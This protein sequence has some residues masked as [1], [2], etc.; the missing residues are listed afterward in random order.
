MNRTEGW[1][2]PLMRGR[3]DSTLDVPLAFE[4]AERI[5]NDSGHGGSRR[6]DATAVRSD[7]RSVAYNAHNRG[8]YRWK[9]QFQ[10][11]PTRTIHA[12]R[13]ARRHQ[14]AGSRESHRNS[15]AAKRIA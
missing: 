6:D 2:C 7:G 5:D 4:P 12:H 10:R 8:E 9:I 14:A 15:T 3:H 11:R 13:G 1:I